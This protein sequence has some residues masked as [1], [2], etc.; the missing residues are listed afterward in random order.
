MSAGHWHAPVDI[1][2]ERVGTTF[3]AE[4]INALTNLAFIIAALWGVWLI[5]QRARPADAVDILLI[6]LAASVG[7]GSF[8]WHSFAERWAELPDA[9]PIWVFIGVY[10]YR[11]IVGLKDNSPARKARI[12]LII[13]AV[14]S[15]V[16]YF[17][18][19][20][21]SGGANA[22]DPLNGTGQYAPALLALV[23][24]TLIAWRRDHPRKA[25]VLAA[26]LTFVAALVFRALDMRLC[27]LFPLGTH[28]LWHLSNA[29]LVALL[30]DIRLRAPK[31]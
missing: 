2:C 25:S 6:G 1:Y 20:G 10:V 26:T 29:L 3:W 12:A 9:G 27:A 24:F 8:L 13:A 19:T 4:P 5:R 30:L 15:V 21:E 14:V 23:A 11:V 16:L 17:M 7:V 31:S 18:A 28:F 22:S